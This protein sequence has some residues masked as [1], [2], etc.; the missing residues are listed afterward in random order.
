MSSTFWKFS[1]I[2]QTPKF[3]RCIIEAP[4][5]DAA[6]RRLKLELSA[7][8]EK[9]WKIKKIPSSGEVTFCLTLKNCVD[10][11]ETLRVFKTKFIN[12]KIVKEHLDANIDKHTVVFYY[13]T[14]EQ[15][16]KLQTAI[17][18]WKWLEGKKKMTIPQVKIFFG[19][20]LI[21][22]YLIEDLTETD[23]IEGN[24]S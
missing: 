1:Q 16:A 19:N 8:S 7:F 3:P 2:L 18:F 24:M 20:N 23:L 14:I 12:F 11:L 6:Q 13:N 22:E 21:K 17:D 10:K 4:T 15:F 9:E 5:K